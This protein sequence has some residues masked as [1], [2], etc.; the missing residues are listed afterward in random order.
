MVLSTWLVAFNL[1]LFFS[2]SLSC[3]ISGRIFLLFALMA[4]SQHGNEPTSDAQSSDSLVEQTI[5][6]AEGP[7]HARDSTPVNPCHYHFEEIGQDLLPTGRYLDTQE[8]AIAG[9]S[10]RSAR[11]LHIAILLPLPDLP[12][13]NDYI[14]WHPQPQFFRFYTMDW[15]IWKM[16][17]GANTR[18][19]HRAFAE[20]GKPPL[21]WQFQFQVAPR[22]AL[23]SLD[24]PNYIRA[25]HRLAEEVDD[26][27]AGNEDMDYNDE[28]NGA[29]EL[30]TWP[31]NDAA[32][33]EVPSDDW[34]D[35]VEEDAALSPPDLPDNHQALCERFGFTTAGIAAM[36]V[37]W[38]PS[39]I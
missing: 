5:P 8:E 28:D 17:T 9:L 18:M 1:I 16:V 3:R 21:L 34:E 20:T 6:P 39:G 22:L 24:F 4:Y 23:S 25:R 29:G 26:Q 32:N 11:R 37:P 7:L 33:I 27:E 19:V 30:S 38:S 15:L 36:A 13:V 10:P 14:G 2:F 31:V 35:D 12:V